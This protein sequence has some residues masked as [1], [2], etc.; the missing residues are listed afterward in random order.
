M[1]QVEANFDSR[2]NTQ[3]ICSNIN[4]YAWSNVG[5]DHAHLAATYTQ[6]YFAVTYTQFYISILTIF[7]SLLSLLL[8]MFFVSQIV[9][10]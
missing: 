3:Q 6:F 5:Y 10:T 8:L 4:L 2:S 1:Q 7:F 9:V